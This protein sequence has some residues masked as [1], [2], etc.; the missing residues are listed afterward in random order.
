ME[1]TIQRYETGISVNNLKNWGELQAVK[2][3]LQNAVYAKTILGDEI[4]IQHDGTFAHI[5]NTPSGFSKGKLLIGE[6]DQAD[7]DGAPGQYGEGMKAAMAVARRSG[8]EC[9]VQTN[10][11][12][13]RPEIEPSSLDKGVDALVFYIEDNDHNKGTMFTIQCSVEIFEEAKKSFA[14]LQGVAPEQVS[15]STMLRGVGEGGNI[16]VNGV[17]IYKTP[18]VFDYNFTNPKL[19][20]RDRSTVDMFE[21]KREV[22]KLLNVMN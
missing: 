22:G 18:A 15:K 4:T 16:Y 17:H 3:F 10:G 8:L 13:V 1:K 20:N 7:V 6:S 19:M 9:F 21:V 14:V 5:G 2:E 12:S 11:F